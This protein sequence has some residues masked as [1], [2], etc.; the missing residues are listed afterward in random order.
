MT[1]ANLEKMYVGIAFISSPKAI[2]QVGMIAA[3][4]GFIYIIVNNIYC[5][6]L[7]LKARNRFKRETIID[8]CDLSARLYGEWTRPF[9]SILLIFTNGCF[10]MCYVM[11]IGT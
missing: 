7:L 4:I 8:I 9:M 2:A 10:L 1:V 6:Y 5:V 3:A 11:Y